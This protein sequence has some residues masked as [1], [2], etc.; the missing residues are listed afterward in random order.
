MTIATIWFIYFTDDA[1]FQLILTLSIINGIGCGGTTPIQYAIVREYNVCDQCEDTAT[2]FVNV[3]RTSSGFIAQLL[4]G[5][6]IDWHWNMR[7]GNDFDNANIRHYSAADYEFA[8][9]LCTAALAV[10]IVTLIL[11]RE[12][13]A[14]IVILWATHMLLIFVD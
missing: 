6:M 8:F 7:G 5:W 9:S 14:K 13:N 11:L 4:M 1:S 2:G 12:P 10:A 3:Q